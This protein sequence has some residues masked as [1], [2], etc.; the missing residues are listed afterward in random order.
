MNVNSGARGST[1]VP[2]GGTAT[3]KC[4]IPG[5]GATD[6]VNVKFTADKSLVL[7]ET[8]FE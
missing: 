6:A 3:V 5:G 4:E 7:L 8:A 1:E 2:P